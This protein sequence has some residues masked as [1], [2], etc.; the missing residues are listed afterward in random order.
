[1]QIVDFTAAHT[2]QATQIAKRNYEAE[3]KFT[4]ALPLIEQWPDLE[5]LAENNL[6]VAAFDGGVMIGFLCGHG[7]WNDAWGIPGLRNVFSPM[8]ANGTIHEN[9]A[10]IYARLY[11][12]AGEKWARAGAA[13]HGICLYAHDAEGQAQF[14]RYGFGMRCIDAIRSIDAICTIDD[15]RTTD[16]IRTANGIPPANDIRPPDNIEAPP[17]DGY[18]LGDVEAPPCGGYSFAELCAGELEEAYPLEKL[19]D[20]GYIESPFFM[21]R[22]PQSK[23]ILL[24]NAARQQSIYYV[25]KRLGNAVAFIRAEHDGE[26]FIQNTPGYI[27][28]KGLYCLPE[29]RG[30]GISQ[31]LLNLLIQKLQKQGYTRLGVDFE[32]INPS[33]SGFWLKYFMAYTHSV[34]RR[35][36][37]NF[38]YF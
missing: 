15:I 5:V 33:G 3:R 10:G 11:Q 27:H 37:E 22:A 25:A 35:I 30:K 26:T 7:V 29:H 13:S 20:E 14:F 9:R 18:T 34:V 36:D 28:C 19:L 12:A 32:S 1:M 6:G 16:D 8:H 4:P 17:C 23:T 24:E 38:Q 31:N 2:G 21:H